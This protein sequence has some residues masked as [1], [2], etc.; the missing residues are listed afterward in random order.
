M[1]EGL[2][3]LILLGRVDCNDGVAAYLESLITGLRE[4]GDRVVV[5]SGAVTTFF[6]SEPR[7]LSIEA[8][9]LEWVVLDGFHASRPKLSHLRRILALVRLHDIDVLNPQGFSVLPLGN[10][11]GRLAS[12]PVVTNFHLLQSDLSA[13][14]RIA[15]RVIAALFPSDRYIAMSRDIA[16]FFRFQCRI[17]KRLIHEQSLG[18]DTEFYRMP[19]EGERREA[20]L[21]FDLDQETLAAVLPGRMNV[22]KG[23]DVAAAALR[24]LRSQRPEISIVCLFAGDGDQRAQIEADVLRDDDDRSTFRFLGFV[25]RQTMRDAYWATDIVMLPSRKEGFPLV[26]CE[27]MCCGAI[28]IRTPSSGWQEQVVEGKTGYMIP[29]EDP[30]ALARA[31]EKVVDS[32]CRVAMRLAATHLASERFSRTRMIAGTSALFRE[33]AALKRSRPRV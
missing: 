8:S 13:R 6:G 30:V 11:V 25:D 2:T 14:K 33:M 12:R 7:R 23:H 21:R 22:T 15:Y 18:V 19:T 31:I 29:F 27:A 26:V 3:I 20:R 4:I 5:V 1:S 16:M 28:V 10:L 24:L 32:S 9:A 17:P